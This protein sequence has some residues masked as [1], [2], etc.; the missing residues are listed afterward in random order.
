MRTTKILTTISFLFLSAL[1]LNA[2][3]YKS[4]DD[5]NNTFEINVHKEGETSMAK[6]QAVRLNKTWFITA[7][8]C[9]KPIC[10]SACSIDARLII[11]DRYEMDISVDHTPTR[12]AVFIH[13]RTTLN[14]NEAGYDIALIN[15][16]PEQ[17]K[18]LYKDRAE[19]M[20]L[21]KNIFEDKAR[22]SSREVSE[23]VDGTNF[24]PVLVLKAETPK[25]LNRQLAVAS[26]WDGGK[27]VLASSGLV[28]YSPK[29]HYIYTNNFGI[30]QGISGSGVMTN[31]G[32]LVGIVSSTAEVVRSC[33]TGN[34][35]ERKEYNFSFMSTFDEYVLNF[36]KRNMGNVNYDISGEDTLKLVPE[37]YKTMANSIDEI[38]S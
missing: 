15:F 27:S 25:L 18:Y 37:E 22:F 29:Q 13:E 9:V 7:A 26:I 30:R 10:D 35:S 11:K 2:Q 19:Q 36:L 21:P 3:S 4:A 38:V 14:K 16:K 33:T 32:E 24:P 34:N 1:A 6:C 17:S 28:F 20:L 23:A 31:K 12:P 8:H 5:F